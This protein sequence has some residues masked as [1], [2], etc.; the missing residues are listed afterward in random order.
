MTALHPITA[1]RPATA[2]EGPAWNQTG[3]ARAIYAAIAELGQIAVRLEALDHQHRFLGLSAMGAEIGRVI[4]TERR[5]GFAQGFEMALAPSNGTCIV[6]ELWQQ[7]VELRHQWIAARLREQGFLERFESEA[8][9]DAYDDLAAL[10][11]PVDTI[12]R[13][14]S[15]QA[16][17]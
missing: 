7:L 6:A 17:A 1:D 4:L 15:G 2:G 11:P 13:E 3:A 12:Q 16:G 14:L 10:A 9:A 8:S 5:V